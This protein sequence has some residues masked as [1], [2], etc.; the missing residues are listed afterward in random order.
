MFEF[1]STHIKTYTLNL[2]KWG[3][4]VIG[5]LQVNGAHLSPN[6]K[7]KSNSKTTNVDYT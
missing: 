5:H 1:F 4:Q 7:T 3:K 6:E 2:Q